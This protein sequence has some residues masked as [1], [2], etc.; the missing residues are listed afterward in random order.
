MYGF[1]YVSMLVLAHLNRKPAK[2]V[3][4]KRPRSAVEPQAPVDLP[5]QHAECLGFR[6][7]GVGF[8]A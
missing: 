2:A 5:P 7:Y 6:V 1:Q 8:R 4:G 3:L